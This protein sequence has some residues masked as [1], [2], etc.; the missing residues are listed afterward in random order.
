[1]DNAN[2]FWRVI[3]FYR[4]RTETKSTIAAERRADRCHHPAITALSSV[5][6]MNII[7]RQ[8]DFPCRPPD[9]HGGHLG[10][11]ADVGQTARLVVATSPCPRPLLEW[12]QA[13]VRLTS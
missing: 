3:E 1:M 4:T 11:A 2:T 8:H 7:E 6:G 10:H 13:M 9:R 5:Y 12:R